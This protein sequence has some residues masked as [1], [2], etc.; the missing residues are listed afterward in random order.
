M[1]LFVKMIRKTEIVFLI[2]INFS[3]IEVINYLNKKWK[4]NFKSKDKKNKRT[5]IQDGVKKYFNFLF[6][7]NN[8]WSICTRMKKL[9]VGKLLQKKWITN[10]PI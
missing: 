8:F 5:L 2:F 3:L 10:F 4:I 7:K 6:R 9:E 1:H